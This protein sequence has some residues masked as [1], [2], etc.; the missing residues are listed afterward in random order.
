MPLRINLSSAGRGLFIA[1][2]LTDEELLQE[3]SRRA[4][5]TAAD[6]VRE[7]LTKRRDSHFGAERLGPL[8]RFQM[9]R[10]SSKKIARVLV[11]DRTARLSMPSSIRKA[12]G[13][14]PLI[15]GEE[16]SDYEELTAQLAAVVQP[17]DMI[18]WAYVRDLADA[19]WEINWLGRWIAAVANNAFIRNNWHDS[20]SDQERVDAILK[21]HR[22][23]PSPGL[24]FVTCEVGEAVQRNMQTLDILYRLLDSAERRRSRVLQEV[25]SYRQDWR[26]ALRTTSDK[27][28]EDHAKEIGSA[29]R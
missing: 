12:L 2:L 8:P 15:V 22:L 11:N 10:P 7:K 13:P 28:I 25:G 20:E 17:N 14:E 1:P 16:L 26:R 5:R 21:E 29:V 19:I 4:G 18:E 9:E 24:D 3:V 23:Q 27:L 6:S